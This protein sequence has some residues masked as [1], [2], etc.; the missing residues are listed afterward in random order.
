MAIPI[1]VSKVKMEKKGRR[2]LASFTVQVGTAKKRFA[3]VPM[4]FDENHYDGIG[5]YIFTARGKTLVR[6]WLELIGLSVVE[7]I[8]EIE[9]KISEAL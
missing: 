7:E 5:I 3:K 2:H 4:I 6:K 9:V 1:D 8:T